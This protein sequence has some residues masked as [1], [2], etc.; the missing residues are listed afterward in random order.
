MPITRTVGL[1]T[2]HLVLAAGTLAQVSADFEEDVREF[3]Q[4]I[5]TLASP[6]MEGRVPGSDGMEVA[7]DYVEFYL[8]R[9]GVEP[10]FDLVEGEDQVTHLASYRQAFPLGGTMEVAGHAIDVDGLQLKADVD[11]TAT[12]MGSSG[13]AEGEV[14]F[15]GYSIDNGPDGYTSFP[16]DADLEGKIA[17]VMRFEPVNEDGETSQWQGRGWSGRASFSNKLR[18]IRE[19]NPAAVIIVNTPETFDDRADSLITPSTDAGRAL[20]VPVFNMTTEAGDR[21]V[22]QLTDGDKTLLDLRKMADEGTAW[23]EFDQE[24]AIAAELKRE[25]LLAENVAGVLYGKGEL[26][27]EII[28]IGAHMDHLG[29]GFFGSRSPEAGRKIHPGADDNASGSAAVI[30]LAERLADDYESLPE[31]TPA[32]TILF[33]LFDAEESGLNGS[34]YYVN[35]PFGSWDDHVLMI[36]FDMIGRVVESKLSV[37]G[38]NTAEGMRDWL[39]PIFESSPLEIVEDSMMGGGS[40]HL[41]FRQKGLPYLFSIC[42]P[43]HAD[44]HTPGDEAYKI[45]AEDGVHTIN[46]YHDILYTAATRPEPIV[47][48]DTAT[49]SRPQQPAGPRM[50]DIKVRFGISP[51]NYDDEK[52]GV[53]VSAITEGGSAEE[54]GIEA[55][56]RIV[57]WNG[58]DIESIMAWMGMLSDHEPGDEVNV[59]LIRE[60]KEMA[61]KV[62]LQA[63]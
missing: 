49:G 1:L 63:R 7:R 22:R 15:V 46:L 21:L 28:V 44:Y 13:E 6:F 8:K 23:V 33:T 40:D 60:G 51:G 2:A 19:H 17:L 43:L 47:A 18:S 12:G 25:P 35:N 34:R 62:T 20:E 39:A 32:R 36:N 59:G 9:A 54:A 24:M 14:V 38:V 26:A 41:P 42:T 61:V 55:G 5:Q 45:N 50:G 29:M 58:K 4:H 53:V 16:E 27:D 48:A 3:D 56:D 37:N 31:G 11:F 52:P 10:P 30:M 57:S